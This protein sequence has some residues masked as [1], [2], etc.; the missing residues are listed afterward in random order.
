MI[1]YRAETAMVPWLLDEHTDSPA[2]RTLLQGLFCSAAD[3]VPEPEHQRLRV[4]VHRSARLVIDQRLC[5]LFA[6][7]NEAE[8]AYP[9]TDLILRYELLADSAAQPQNG[10]PSSS[11][12]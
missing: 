8:L 9:G 7:L 10:V 3:I 11:A 5:R 12:R 4:C 6:V 1:A 2:A